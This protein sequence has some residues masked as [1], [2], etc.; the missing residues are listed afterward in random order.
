MQTQPLDL[1]EQTLEKLFDGGVCLT[2][3]PMGATYWGNILERERQYRAQHGVKDTWVVPKLATLPL[4]CYNAPFHFFSNG[5][6]IHAFNPTKDY[7]EKLKRIQK[8][9]SLHGY[10]V[11]KIYGPQIQFDIFGY[12]EFLQKIAQY[13]YKKYPAEQNSE[14][15]S[16]PDKRSFLKNCFANNNVLLTASKF[17][18][19]DPTCRQYL[20][21]FEDGMFF[22]STD[23]KGGN[24]INDPSLIYDFSF[25]YNQYVYFKRLYVP[26]DYIDALYVK[27]KTFDWYISKEESFKNLPPQ[28]GLTDQEMLQ[29]SVYIA[30]LLKNR[31]CISVTLPPSTAPYTFHVEPRHDW[32]VLFN[33]GKLI[34]SKDRHE[35]TNK[36]QIESLKLSYPNLEFD[37]EYVPEHYISAIYNEVSKT[38]KTAK[39]IYLEVLKQKAKRLKKVLEIS[40]HEALEISAKMVGFKSFKDALNI[41]E[42]NARYAIH[43][44]QEA[45]TG[46]LKRGKDYILE[47]YKYWQ[48]SKEGQ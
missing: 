6:L 20:A 36:A 17:E 1:N 41:T 16:I 10:K 9:L 43:R 12:S 5:V 33:D 44:D 18:Q 14:I 23:Y 2:F 7:S 19:I 39:D 40:H 46:A 22:V 38:Q 42:Q 32:Y 37:I 34:L 30:D 31:R 27:A 47:Q 21:L 11:T 35:I 3:N 28:E 45:K 13:A 8:A 15:V 29:M 24:P 48:R 26:Q 25:K 4:E